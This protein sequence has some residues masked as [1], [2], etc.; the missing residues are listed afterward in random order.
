MENNEKIAKDYS[1]KDNAD[2]KTGSVQEDS[3]DASPSLTGDFEIIKRYDPFADKALS[4]DDLLIIQEHLYDRDHAENLEIIKKAYEEH[5]DDELLSIVHRGFLAKVA[6]GDIPQITHKEWELLAAFE[7]FLIDEWSIYPE[8]RAVTRPIEEPDDGNEEYESLRVYVIGLAWCLSGAVLYTFFNVR[9]P[10]VSITSTGLDVLIAGSGRLW[11]MLPY[12][13]IPLGKG[14][15]LVINNG[16]PWTF[17]EQMLANMMTVANQPA[18]SQDAVLAMANNYFYGIEEAKSFGFTILLTL[19]QNIM[20]FGIAGIVRSIAI[21]PTQMAWFVILPTLSLNRALVK[22]DVR[23]NINGWKL[24]QMEF[25]WI[26]AWFAFGW[27]WITDF[28]FMALSVFTWPTWIAPNNVNL[29]AI[30]GYATG[31]GLNPITTFDLNVVSFS[32]LYTPYASFLTYYGGMF[33]GMIAIIV[34]WFTNA[35]WTGYFPINSNGIYDNT[36]ASYN[37]TNVLDPTTFLLSKEKLQKYS[38]PFYTA[39]LLVY[40]GVY[41]MEYPAMIVFVILN[42]YKYFIDAVPSIIH[43]LFTG[44]GVSEKFNDSF[45]RRL[46]RYKEVPEWWFLVVLI[47]GFAFG[48]ACVEHYKFTN[49]PVW[50]IVL[51]IAISLVF[52]GPA[53]ILEARTTYTFFINLLFEVIIGYALPGNGNAL[54]ISKGIAVMC[55][56]QGYDYLNSLAAAQ[57]VTIAPRAVFRVQI[58]AMVFAS[59]VM[60]GL[61]NWQASG[62][63]PDF[64]DPENTTTKFTCQNPRTYFINAVQFGTIGPARMFEGLYPKLKWCFLIGAV[65]PLPFWMAR[66]LTS[67]VSQH[68]PASSRVS[69]W[70]RAL[71]LWL[72]SVNEIVIL[73]GALNWAPNNWYYQISNLEVGIFWHKYVKVRF[74]RWWSKYTFPFYNAISVGIAYSNLIMFFSTSYKHEASISWWGNTVSS[75]N[76]DALG[77]ATR[78]VVDEGEYIGPTKGTFPGGNGTS[79]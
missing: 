9:Y 68:E 35:R 72:A 49:T 59:F 33:I 41:F 74:P 15:K 54:M 55:Q 8:V 51:G 17:K 56:G 61:V 58:V 27:F 12:I 20:G 1:G 24:T 31:L 70:S 43:G 6:T 30:C 73:Q 57:Y 42:W 28:V 45:S 18:Y 48:V 40:T 75:N 29:Q 71:G 34:L 39:G 38:L 5:K 3:I 79:S 13:A 78:F 47:V 4:E 23:E 63:I 37:V 50:T 10:T 64:C 21:Y 66:K 36:G 77:N 32:T 2:I 60:A 14:R 7:A 76:A 22:G 67:R 16:K 26:I 62:A 44:K 52:I 11:S 25:F 19:C 53:A 69:R 46:R 65:Y